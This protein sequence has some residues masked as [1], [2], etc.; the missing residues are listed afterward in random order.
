MRYAL[1]LAAVFVLMATVAESAKQPP[2]PKQAV[3]VVKVK[4]AEWTVA[5]LP[6]KIKA[7]SIRFDVTNSGTMTHAL[8]I[9]GV[10]QATKNIDPGENTS[11]TVTLKPGT[12][13]LYCPVRGHRGQGMEAKLKVTK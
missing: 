9:V 2:K 3:A 1:I 10:K 4:L 7:G 12:Y 6:T 8:A 5:P 13:T 11:L